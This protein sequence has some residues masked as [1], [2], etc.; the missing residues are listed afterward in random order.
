MSSLTIYNDIHYD[1]NST[2]LQQTLDLILPS[3]KGE[4][5]PHPP[6]IIIIHGGAWISGD[7]KEFA[8]LGSTICKLS[9]FAVALVNYRLSTKDAPEI[10]HPAHVEDVAAS[11]AWISKHGEQYGYLG[12]RIYLMGHSVGAFICGQLIFMPEFIGRHDRKLFQSIRSVIGI[13]GIYDIPLLLEVWPKYIDFVELAFGKD[14]SVYKNSSPTNNSVAVSVPSHLIIHSMEDELVDVDQSYNY[15]E[16]V[17]KCGGIDLE[18][19][20][21]LKGNHEG[22]LQTDELANVVV[23][24]ILI[25]ESKE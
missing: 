20:N 17:K 12:D 3:G 6:V 10:K 2:N 24:F 22:I 5:K 21:S 11:I 15:F 18:M 16:H 19:N 1:P 14:E 23:K 8:K 25:K 9:N 4:S 13:Q 7:K